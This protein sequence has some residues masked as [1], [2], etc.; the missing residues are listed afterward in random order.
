MNLVNTLSRA[1]TIVPHVGQ[2]LAQ[3]PVKDIRALPSSDVHKKKIKTGVNNL[4]IEKISAFER[5]FPKLFFVFSFHN[6][7]ESLFLPLKDHEVVDL[8]HF[9]AKY[10]C[11]KY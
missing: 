9:S 5:H 8:T 4:K 10:S 7:L 11:L 1:I 6:N 2:K 3:N